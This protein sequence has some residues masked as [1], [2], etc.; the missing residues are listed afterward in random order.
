MPCTSDHDTR[1]SSRAGVVLYRLRV[2]TSITTLS[3]RS[4]REN[5]RRSADLYANR[6][7]DANNSGKQNG[8]LWRAD[9]RSKRLCSTAQA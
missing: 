1:R 5:A 4:A 6:L 7:L 3:D 8:S 2:L 9:T